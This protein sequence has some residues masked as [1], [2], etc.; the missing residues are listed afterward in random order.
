[1]DLIWLC[2]CSDKAQMTSEGPKN[3][4]LHMSYAN[5]VFTAF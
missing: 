4:E 1:M 5:D 3:K 2:V